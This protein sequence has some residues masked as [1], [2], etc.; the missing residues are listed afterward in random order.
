MK[1]IRHLRKSSARLRSC[2]AKGKRR[3]EEEQD[4]GNSKQFFDNFKLG[5]PF[6]ASVFRPNIPRC[7][8]NSADPKE[9]DETSRISLPMFKEQQHTLA[10]EI[11][12][13]PAAHGRACFILGSGN[14]E[15][16]DIL[17]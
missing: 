5:G 13:F 17:Q 2:R 14:A 1:Q 11:G 6:T 8:S 12:H 15:C 4:L 10:F 3:A 16:Q 9:T 7:R